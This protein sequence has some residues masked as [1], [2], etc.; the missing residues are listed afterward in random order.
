MNRLVEIDL[1]IVIC[2][3]CGSSIFPI[4]FKCMNN[5]V[6][7]FLNNYC[8]VATDKALSVKK[9][10]RMANYDKVKSKEQRKLITFSKR[11]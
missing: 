5:I 1:G 6:N 10:V 2:D 7:I 9:N 4:I 8:K 11:S 3:V